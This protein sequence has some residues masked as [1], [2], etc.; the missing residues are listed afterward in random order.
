MANLVGVEDTWRP[1][2]DEDATTDELRWSGTVWLAEDRQVRRGDPEAVTAAAQRLSWLQTVFP[3][4]RLE[5]AEGPW[6]VVSTSGHPAHRPDLQPI[7]DD[8]PGLVG[9]A[10]R[11]LHDLETAACPFVAGW[12]VQHA[13]IEAAVAADRL[14][15]SGLPD[16]YNR[17]DP[18]RLLDLLVE[19]RPDEVD[20]VVCHG[21]PVLPNLWF[22]QG[23]L[24]A[25]T[26]HHRLGLADPHFDLAVAHRSVQSWFGGEAVFGLYEG[27]GSDP[28]LVR[29]DHY[30]LMDVLLQ[31]VDRS[32]PFMTTSNEGER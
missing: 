16:P 8:V 32:G 19:G 28:D 12:E 13:T 3:T 15:V 31:A 29:L 20:P 6:L 2:P 21:A 5:H 23:G 4:A 27:Y 22:D 26:G 9:T 14:E 7:P 1:Y 17:Y 18:K 11:R 30:V 25:T 10:L 24:G